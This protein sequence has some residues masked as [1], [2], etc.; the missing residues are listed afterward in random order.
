MRPREHARTE[1]GG[2][3]GFNFW[4]GLC[5]FLVESWW[6]MGDVGKDRGREGGWLVASIESVEVVREKCLL[7]AT[8]IST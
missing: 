5:R 1:E 7:A 4:K 3:G 2:R 6:A 8:G